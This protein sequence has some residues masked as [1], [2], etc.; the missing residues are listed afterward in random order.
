MA[1]LHSA[2]WRPA[3]IFLTQKIVWLEWNGCDEGDEAAG[4]GAA[5]LEDAGSLEINFEWRHRGNE[6]V[7]KA[8]KA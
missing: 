7:L 8:V 4:Q 3:S 5:H 1:R 2:L 6:A